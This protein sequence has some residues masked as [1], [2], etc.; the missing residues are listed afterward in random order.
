MSFATRTSFL[1]STELLFYH[2]YLP[3]LSNSLSFLYSY[4]VY[5]FIIHV[6]LSYFPWSRLLSKPLSSI[7]LLSLSP[8]ERYGIPAGLYP[9]PQSHT[10]PLPGLVFHFSYHCYIE[11]SPVFLRRPNLP[12]FTSLRD[13]LL[14]QLQLLSYPCLLC[15]YSGSAWQVSFLKSF[16][17]GP[18]IFAK[19]FTNH[20]KK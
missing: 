9:I 19:Q 20:W 12:R 15:S 17:R 3:L 6:I 2:A 1:P 10:A 8:F 5:A 13:F 11:W 18:A 4:A 7:P 14:P 16:V